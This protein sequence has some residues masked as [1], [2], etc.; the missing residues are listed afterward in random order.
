MATLDEFNW[1]TPPQ[2]QRRRCCHW[3]MGVADAIFLLTE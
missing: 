3:V 1:I 2:H